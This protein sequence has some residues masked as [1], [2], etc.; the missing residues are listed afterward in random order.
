MGMAG[1]TPLAA[2]MTP[3]GTAIA[4]MATPTPSAAM[5]LYGP[6]S[7]TPEQEQ[8]AK[9]ERELAERNRELTDAELDDMFKDVPGFKVIDP[10]KNYNPD[11]SSKGVFATPTPMTA[12]GG[13]QI[14]STPLREDYGIAATPQETGLPHIN[15][16]DE[17]YF[18][19]LLDQVRVAR[20]CGC[21][22]C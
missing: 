18:K 12:V 20:V 7:S 1:A 11:R 15:P 21:V 5:G 22:E 16:E 3:V 9:W 4:A 13:F 8:R 19:D 2:G 17:K 14:Q 10:P 6:A